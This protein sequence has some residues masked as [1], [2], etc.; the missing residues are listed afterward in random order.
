VEA[1]SSPVV[2]ADYRAGLA[3]LLELLYADGHR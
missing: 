1:S 3:E 2:A